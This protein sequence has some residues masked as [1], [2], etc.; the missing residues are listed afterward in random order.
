VSISK[1]HQDLIDA[2]AQSMVGAFKTTT[3]GLGLGTKEAKVLCKETCGSVISDTI[4]QSEDNYMTEHKKENIGW[5][6]RNLNTFVAP[7]LLATQS[8]GNAVGKQ[9]AAHST[10]D[11]NLEAHSMTPEQAAA[12]KTYLAQQEQPATA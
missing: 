8:A 10:E 2:A 5:L 7:F 12:Y 1:E 3:K 11:G 4:T 9:R 6:Q